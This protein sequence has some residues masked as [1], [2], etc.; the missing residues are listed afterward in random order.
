MDQYPKNDESQKV[1]Q[2]FQA[3]LKACSVDYLCR[4]FWYFSELVDLR[5]VDAGTTTGPQKVSYNL[6]TVGLELN[7]RYVELF[8]THWSVFTLSHCEK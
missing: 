1:L 4:N 2:Q 5:C 8:E 6:V 7:V 3:Y